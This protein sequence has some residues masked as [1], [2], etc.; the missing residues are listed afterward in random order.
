MSAGESIMK[1]RAISEVPGPL[2][3]PKKQQPSSP[4]GPPSTGEKEL[5]YVGAGKYRSERRRAGRKR[6]DLLPT[7]Q[8]PDP[9][10]KG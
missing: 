9:K 1:A 6:K 7:K 5:G 4:E 3:K 10:K 8:S 2:E